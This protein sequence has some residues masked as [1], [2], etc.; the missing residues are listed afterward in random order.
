MTEFENWAAHTDR[1][2]IIICRIS[3]LII[4]SRCKLVFGDSDTGD[5]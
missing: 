1:R 5:F 2:V 4:K 3:R